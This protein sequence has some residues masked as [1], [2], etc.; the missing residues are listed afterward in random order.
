[1]LPTTINLSDAQTIISNVVEQADFKAVEITFRFINGNGADKKT[2]QDKGNGGDTV[3][4]IFPEEYIALLN[5]AK[6]VKQLFF[7]YYQNEKEMVNYSLAD[8][9]KVKAAL[10]NKKDA[11]QRIGK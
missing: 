1:M 9:N 2:E 11:L 10:N 4:A 8:K 3:P 7:I 5:K 6:T